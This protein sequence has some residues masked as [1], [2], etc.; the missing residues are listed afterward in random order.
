MEF[1]ALVVLVN[2][3]RRRGIISPRITAGC[4]GRGGNV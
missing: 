4:C 2:A 3:G 1:D